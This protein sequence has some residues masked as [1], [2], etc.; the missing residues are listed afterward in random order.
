MIEAGN[1]KTFEQLIVENTKLRSDCE[2]LRKMLTDER[3]FFLE[4]LK[5]D[6]VEEYRKLLYINSE[7]KKELHMATQDIS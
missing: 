5:H 7:H 2:F 6:S 4:M 1:E 3:R